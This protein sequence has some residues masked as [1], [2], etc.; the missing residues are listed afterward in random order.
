MEYMEHSFA[1][2]ERRA[3]EAL[4]FGRSTHR[5]QS[6]ADEQA[7]LRMRIKE[8][9]GTRVRYGYK[10]IHVLLQ[11]EGWQINHKRV[12]RLYREAGLNLRTKK[13]KKRTRAVQWK[14]REEAH[15]LNDSWSM[16]FMSDSLFN[17]RRFRALT[18]VDNFSRECLGIKAD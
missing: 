10:R 8:I 15:N 4:R 1:V 13:S 7:V 2:S 11:R 6:R 14:H 12:Y 16:D 18:V 3:C 9:A 5:Y 17:G